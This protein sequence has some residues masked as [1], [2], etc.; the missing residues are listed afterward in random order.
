MPRSHIYVKLLTMNKV[1]N[2]L[3]ILIMEHRQNVSRDSRKVSNVAICSAAMKRSFHNNL[4][5][6]VAR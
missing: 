4:R 6:F 1:T 2:F 5:Y 3:L